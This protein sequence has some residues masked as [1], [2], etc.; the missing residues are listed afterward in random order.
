MAED[1]PDASIES[2]A[3]K[4]PSVTPKLIEQV[5]EKYGDPASSETGSPSSDVSKPTAADDYPTESDLSES[6][7]KVL[8][9]IYQNPEASQRELAE[10][11]GVSAATVSNRANSI[12]G[13]DWS[14]RKA[15][16]EAVLDIE[17]ASP[18]Q[19]AKSMFDRNSENS[20]VFHEL[21]ERV[22]ALEEQREN[23]NGQQEQETTF[24]DTEL[25]HKMVHACIQYEEIS[26]D[27][28]RRILA[29]FIE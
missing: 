2:I 21:E 13:F 9:A 24:S 10:D 19:N 7:R 14:D 6:Q 11:I 3:K 12:R 15:F 8:H 25:V 16:V 5:L 22:S 20:L 27:E 28:E 18:E 26:D 23:R 29:L 17:T 1:N 4:V